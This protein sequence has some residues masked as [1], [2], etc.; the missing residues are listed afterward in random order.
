[1]LISIAWRNVWR[2]KLRSGI[3]ITAIT[4]GLIAGIFSTAVYEGMVIQRVDKVIMSELSHIQVHEPGFRNSMELTGF[5]PDAASIAS[6]INNIEGVAGV[7]KRIIVYSMVSSAETGAGVRITGVI[8]EEEKKVS[9]IHTKLVEGNYFEKETKSKRIK[10][11]VIGQKLAEKLKVHLGSKVVITL[12]DINNDLT[13]APFRI[14]G[15]FNTMSNMFDEGNVYVRYE[16][17]RNLTGL[18][19][20]AAH[21][22]AILAMNNEM[23]E[24][25]KPEVEA[26]APGLEVKTWINLSPEMSYLNEAMDL[27]LYIFI[28][29]IL[30]ALL[31]G[32]INTMLMAVL[33]R[34]KEIGMLMAIGMNKIRVFTL[35]MYETVFLTLTGGLLGVILGALISIYF[36]THK[37]DLS[38][39]A[40]GYMELGYDPFV[41]TSLEYTMLGNVTIMVLITGLLAS[42]YP[43]WKALSYNPADALRIE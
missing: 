18:P 23:A 4:L 9:N 11:I 12:Q 17:L 22:I 1:M 41:Y 10:P 13:G 2:N 14:R 19:D 20:G 7:S 35:I 31:F 43:A 40:E 5:I 34:T 26:V 15:I 27:Y 3:I 25:L 32:I 24:T 29:I 33:E 6:K 21:E 37:I 30:F 42:I 38:L 8:P 36:E 39:W 28:V 16:D